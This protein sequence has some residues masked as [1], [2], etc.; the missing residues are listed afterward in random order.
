MV[1]IIIWFYGVSKFSIDDFNVLG[2]D[3]IMAVH[4]HDFMQGSIFTLL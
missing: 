3:K 4:V 2:I 1:T